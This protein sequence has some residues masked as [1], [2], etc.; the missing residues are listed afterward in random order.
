M[1]KEL[2]GFHIKKVK[3][4]ES[5]LQTEF[6]KIVSFMVYA[7]VVLLPVLSLPQLI[8]IWIERSATGVSPITWFGFALF[9]VVWIFYGYYHQEKPIFYLNIALLLMDLAIAIGALLY[10]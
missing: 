2:K 9:A 10:G 8:R 3:I 7:S 5:V 4:K 1:E 6:K